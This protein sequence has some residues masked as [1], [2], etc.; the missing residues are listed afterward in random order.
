MQKWTHRNS[1]TK[2]GIEL[3]VD[4]SKKHRQNIVL[5]NQDWLPSKHLDMHQANP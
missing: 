4:M 3:D 1:S 2:L 5:K